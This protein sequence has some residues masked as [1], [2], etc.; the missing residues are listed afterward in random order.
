MVRVILS[1]L[2]QT[3][4]P[5]TLHLYLGDL[6]NSEFHFLRR[7]KHV[8]VCMEEV[9]MKIMLQ[10]VWNEIRE[11]RKLMEAYEVIILTNTTNY[12]L[13]NGNPIFF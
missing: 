6:K 7:V 9:E 12:I 5:D 2:I 10:K 3:M 13:T 1:T 11:R 8:K 4:S